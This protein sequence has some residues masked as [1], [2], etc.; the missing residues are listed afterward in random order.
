MPCVT[1][2]LRIQKTNELVSPESLVDDIPLSDEAAQTVAAARG[3]ISA[4]L[5]G[6]DDRL[7]VV[8]GPCSIHDPKAARDYARGLK[9]AA[10]KH[11]A[12]LQIVMRVYFEKP[13]TTVGWKG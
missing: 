3:A 1:D 5:G 8:V 9:D 10:E 12:D 4:I 11:A 7:L 6:G 13:R 2:D